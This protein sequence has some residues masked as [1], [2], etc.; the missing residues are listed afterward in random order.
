M[1]QDNNKVC[2][3]LERGVIEK[4]HETAIRYPE[5]TKRFE[6]I[7]MLMNKTYL[8]KNKDYSSANISIAGDVGVLIR[9]WD[10]FCRLCNLYNV[11]FPVVDAKISGMIKEIESSEDQISKDKVV[12]LLN[13]L[14]KS[15]E[16]D[17]SNIDRKKPDNEPINDAWLDLALYSIIGLL[18]LEGVW[19]K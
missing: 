11:P 4:K 7:L 17:F 5:Q 13:S 16:F 18:K 1:D 10:K 19:G 3:P 6:E 15:L 14:S 9:V 2:V 12:Y 8:S